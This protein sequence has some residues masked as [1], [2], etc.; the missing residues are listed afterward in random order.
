[1]NVSPL[2]LQLVQ[3]SIDA[4][5]SG[6]SLKSFADIQMKSA[7]ETS[8]LFQ[9][10][11]MAHSHR[12]KEEKWTLLIQSQP[13]S[14]V[15]S[16][17]RVLKKSYE[18]LPVLEPLKSLEAEIYKLMEEEMEVYNLSLAYK[19]LLP[20]FIFYFPALLLLIFTPLYQEFLKLGLI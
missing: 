13:S 14:S 10:T 16:Y 17:L 12:L 3:S 19:A 1:M 8:V 4:L 15:K 5:L 2:S 18:G 20:T 7:Q 11:L 6:Q 9:K